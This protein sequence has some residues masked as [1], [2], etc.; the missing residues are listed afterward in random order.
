MK[1]ASKFIALGI[2]ASLALT[3]VSVFA[4][5]V[6]EDSKLTVVFDGS[7]SIVAKSNDGSDAET[8]TIIKTGARVGISATNT[9]TATD[10]DLNVIFD[11]SKSIV[12]K[13]NDGSDGETNLDTIITS[14][15][16][17]GSSS[18]PVAETAV[19]TKTYADLAITEKNLYAVGGY[20]KGVYPSITGADALNKRIEM[21][22]LKIMQG[23]YTAENYPA[24]QAVQGLDSIVQTGKSNDFTAS[25]N[26]PEN[27]GRYAKVQIEL[28]YRNSVA[29]INPDVI[30]LEYYVD[31][32]GFVEMSKASFDKALADIK[33]AEE[34]AAAAAEAAEEAAAEE[35][36]VFLVPVRAV[37]EAIGYEVGW[38]GENLAVTLTKDDS[39]VSFKNGENSYTIDS[40]TIELEV[41]PILVDGIT[42]VPSSL[43]EALGYELAL[44][45]E[46]NIEVTI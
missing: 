45:E 17:V 10:A 6:T 7:K 35:K 15:N 40:K 30:I 12:A 22:L 41:A 20:H 44:D 8:D 19:T 43:F 5:E 39:V 34:A 37:A 42:Q 33:A 26:A 29:K 13:S 11:G 32:E 25:Y 4:A 16:I 14:G 9:G 28:L 38:D 3:S 1:K 2:I 36:E 46:G 24:Y 31:K 27:F 21:D 18:Q 23:E